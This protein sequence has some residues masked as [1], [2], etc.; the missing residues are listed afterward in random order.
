[1]LYMFLFSHIKFGLKLI[2]MRTRASERKRQVTQTAHWESVN[3]IEFFE[4]CSFFHRHIIIKRYSIF[5]KKYTESLP[6]YGAGKS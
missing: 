6:I 3:S 4:Y 2:H 5:L 1:M